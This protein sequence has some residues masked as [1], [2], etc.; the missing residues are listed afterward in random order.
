MG[1]KSRSKLFDAFIA[2]KGIFNA[3]EADLGALRKEWY[4]KYK[5]EWRKR[6]GSINKELRVSFNLKEFEDFKQKA[7]GFGFRPTA[8]LKSIAV[9]TI[10]NTQVIPEID[11]LLQVL[12]ELRMASISANYYQLG[13]TESK[14][15]EYIKKYR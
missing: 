2:Q 15:M 6:Q 12:Q 5:R 8:F 9:K 1:R 4:R 13:E 11:I 14:L 3:T 10:Q 7:S